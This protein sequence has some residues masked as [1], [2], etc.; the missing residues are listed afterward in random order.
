[1]KSIKQ[2]FEPYKHFYILSYYLV[3]LA[4]YNI[5]NEI[6]VPKYFMYCKLDDYIP[7]VKEMIVP[8]LF[9][10]LYI[11]GALIYLGFTARKDFYNLACFMFTGMTLCFVI[12]AIF[13][14]GQNLRPVIKESDIFSRAV[15]YIY[16][17]DNPTNSAPS[18]HVLNAIAVHLALT[19]C[20]ALA[21]KVWLKVGSF[22]TMVLI[23]M[24]TVMLKQHSILDAMYGV[25]LSILLYFII[26]KIDIVS[27]FTSTRA[28]DK[29][30]EMFE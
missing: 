11:A 9:W 17:V 29:E 23:I 19:K 4:L 1:M 22:I 25:L 5:Y 18:M 27:Y 13:P 21:G 12:F 3:I 15:Q 7:F 16:M 8:Y 6:T 26:Y 20:A 28:F 30:K 2:L 14:N 10:Y 24:S